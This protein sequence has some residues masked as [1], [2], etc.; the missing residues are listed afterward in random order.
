MPGGLGPGRMVI[1]RDVVA[2][3]VPAGKTAY[4]AGLSSFPDAPGDVMRVAQN[5]SYYLGST[6]SD[7]GMIGAA[8]ATGGTAPAVIAFGETL[9]N[10]LAGGA[11]RDRDRQ[12]R[13]NYFGQLAAGGNVAAAQILLGAIPNVS[14]NEQPMWQAW[15]D[16][17][18]SSQSGQATL[19]AARAAGP[20]WLPG[21]TDTVTN[22]PQLKNYVA[23]WQ[24]A[25]PLSAAGPAAAVAAVT[26]SAAFPWIVGLG[27]LGAV[28]AL[29]GRR[30]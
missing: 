16:Q 11:Q 30:R 3:I 4:R 14:G 9:L 6:A 2:S 23:Q 20:Y 17:L 8:Y 26:K 5:Y 19:A 25:H 27:I 13:A 24:A 29:R 1:G 7:V 18:S 12:A 22:Y 28:V 21:S 15:I 10:N